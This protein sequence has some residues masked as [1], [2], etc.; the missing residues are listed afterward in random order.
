MRQRRLPSSGRVAGLALAREVRMV[1]DLGVCRLS[2]VLMAISTQLGGAFKGGGRA[3]MALETGRFRMRAV[4]RKAVYETRGVPGCLAVA[5]GARARANALMRRM[6]GRSK[7]LVVAARAARRRPL[8]SCVF[9]SGAGRKRDKQ[10][11]NQGQARPDECAA[12]GP[13]AQNFSSR[14]VMPRRLHRGVSSAP[15][16]AGPQK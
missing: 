11:A 13:T 5:G 9:S 10:S 15:S 8:C 2:I 7:I 4:E 12:I 14:N 16:P 6:S 1:F 3:A